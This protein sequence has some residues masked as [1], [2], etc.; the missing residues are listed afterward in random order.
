MK[1]D[2]C[3]CAWSIGP[4]AGSLLLY[5][6]LFGTYSFLD[7]NFSIIGPN[8]LIKPHTQVAYQL[9]EGGLVRLC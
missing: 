7:D 2:M 1:G 4:R 9:I 6:Y 8:L 5:I 3:D